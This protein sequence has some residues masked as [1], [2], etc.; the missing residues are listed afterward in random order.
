MAERFPR[1]SC[2]AKMTVAGSLTIAHVSKLELGI[3]A[4]G[5]HV[6]SVSNPTHYALNTNRFGTKCL[7]IHGDRL[8]DPD[9]V[10]QGDKA[11]F[12]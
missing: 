8:G 7:D 2:V 4:P 5:G 9:R 11:P 1:K 10:C 3:Y 6:K 12:G